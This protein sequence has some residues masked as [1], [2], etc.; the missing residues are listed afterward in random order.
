LATQEGMLKIQGKKLISC[1]YESGLK[2]LFVVNYSREHQTRDKC[3]DFL[4]PNFRQKMDSIKILVVS[5]KK[6]S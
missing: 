1:F 3:Y 4:K 6:W 5:A 2:I